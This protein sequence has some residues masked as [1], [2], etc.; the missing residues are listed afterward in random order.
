VIIVHHGLAPP[1]TPPLALEAWLGALPRQRSV[2]LSNLRDAGAQSASLLG[3]ALL[4]SAACAAGYG[5]PAWAELVLEPGEPPRWPGGPTFSISHAGAFV[6]CAVGAP[7]ALL[8][9]D[10]EWAGA[11]A[12]ADLR[13]V[14]DAAEREAMAEGRIGAAALWVAKE[15][16]LKALGR[17]VLHAAQVHVTA[18]TGRLGPA[19]VGLRWLELAAGLATAVACD[20]L[21]TEV[22]TTACD[23]AA[24]LA[25]GP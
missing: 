14:T 4:A 19:Q 23:G 18:A 1:Q 17:G 3:L 12:A 20:A 15:A 9:L 7:G 25:A 24:L 16:V 22:V 8:G 13:L 2:Q 6:A 5:R 21:P 10:A 11:V